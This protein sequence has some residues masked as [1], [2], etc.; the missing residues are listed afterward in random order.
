MYLGG[1]GETKG[2]GAGES[3]KRMGPSEVH[4]LEG[5][6]TDA[7]LAGTS[8]LPEA[9]HGSRWEAARWRDQLGW[10]EW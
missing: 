3:P 2:F 9:R 7:R 10:G 8:S 1:G 6:R 4:M 5:W